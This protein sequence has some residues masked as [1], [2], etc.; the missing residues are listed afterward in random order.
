MGRRNGSQKQ[1]VR[2][3]GVG[4]VTREYGQGWIMGFK[5]GLLGL[6]LQQAWA[7]IK[8]SWG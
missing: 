1:M 3:K 4:H 7:R 6:G 5:A 8:Y 2:G